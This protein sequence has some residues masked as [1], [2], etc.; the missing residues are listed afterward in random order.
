[1]HD[2]SFI[3]YAIISVQIRHFS[4]DYSSSQF[5]KD[6]HSKQTTLIFDAHCFGKWQD[7]L[8]ISIEMAAF[9]HFSLDNR[10]LLLECLPEGLEER[11][12][13]SCTFC[14]NCGRCR[15]RVSSFSWIFIIFQRENLHF[16]GRNHY[17]QG[18][19]GFIF[20]WR[21]ASFVLYKSIIDIYKMAI[22]ID[23][24]QKYGA[25]VSSTCW[26]LPIRTSQN[27][28]KY[29]PKCRPRSSGKLMEY[30]AGVG[31][32]LRRLAQGPRDRAGYPQPWAVTKV[33]IFKRRIIMLCCRIIIFY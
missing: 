5:R 21:M 29:R 15:L 2:S 9:Q 7:L 8:Q 10:S 6:H 27:R 13:L 32:G 22:Y 23:Y 31:T 28:P 11:G 1:M 33:I 25:R 4:T 26:Y 24:N 17:L 14:W 20:Y 12:I 16:Q 3:T 30:V 19:N 18:R